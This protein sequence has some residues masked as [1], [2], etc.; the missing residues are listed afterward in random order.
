MMEEGSPRPSD[1]RPPE[2]PGGSPESELSAR[3]PRSPS[4]TT[5]LLIALVLLAQSTAIFLCKF[6]SRQPAPLR[7]P[8]PPGD[9]IVD[10]LALSV[11]HAVAVVALFVSC[12]HGCC[13]ARPRTGAG[14]PP[15][16]HTHD[17]YGRDDGSTTMRDSARYERISMPPMT[18]P[19]L[20]SGEGSEEKEEKL[21]ASSA[22]VS[23]APRAAGEAGA[24]SAGAAT[25]SKTKPKHAKKSDAGDDADD[26][27]EDARLRARRRAVWCA[28]GAHVCYLI[29][30]SFWRLF[31]PVK[32]DARALEFWA[33]W[34]ALTTSVVAPLLLGHLVATRFLAREVGTARAREGETRRVAPPHHPGV[35]CVYVYTQTAGV[36]L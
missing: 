2:L 17:E 12:Y 7:W 25:S 29:F 21:G 26:E 10:L 31:A 35:V 16:P 27:P 14:A 6:F 24:A 34:A 3:P 30:K 11:A 1:E 23:A 33:F 4:R 13:C 36:V 9:A 15:E 28:I 5:V 18:E 22:A 32:H 19:L 8:F 20:E